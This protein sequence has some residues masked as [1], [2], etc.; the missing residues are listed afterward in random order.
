MLAGIVF[1]LVVVVGGGVYRTD[2]LLSSGQLVTD[3]GPKGDIPYLWSPGPNCR[4]HTLIRY[5]LGRVGV[6]SPARTLDQT[7]P[8]LVR[9]AGGGSVAMAQLVP[10][11]ESLKTVGG[12]SD[13]NSQQAML[14]LFQGQ[15]SKL[16]ASAPSD[17]QQ[18]EPGVGRA[19]RPGPHEAERARGIISGAGLTRV[20][21][22]AR[23]Q[24][25][26]RSWTTGTRT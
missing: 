2:C 14:D 19:H 21:S 10:T 4:A 15:L 26:R 13:P 18:R 12:F 1:F 20:R 25:R 16:R 22:W 24:T 17:H 6:M 8:E 7:S 23:P 5:V 3:W 9:Q 11:L